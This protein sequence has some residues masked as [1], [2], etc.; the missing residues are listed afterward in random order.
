MSIEALILATNVVVVY[1]F[2][3]SDTASC[4]F[5]RLFVGSSSFLTQRTVAHVFVGCTFFVRLELLFLGQMRWDMSISSSLYAKY[6]FALR[7]LAEKR[8]FRR[9]YNE[10]MKVND[11]TSKPQISR[12]CV[13]SRFSS[14][15]LGFEEVSA[16]WLRF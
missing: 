6:Y 13:C 14:V 1:T 12:V 3:V 10:V 16:I 2:F 15:F 9:R 11:Q 8:D 7:S 5:V 4:V